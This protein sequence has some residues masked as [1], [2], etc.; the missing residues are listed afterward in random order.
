MTAAGVM[1]KACAETFARVALISSAACRAAT[2]GAQTVART[3]AFVVRLLLNMQSA[4]FDAMLR[5]AVAFREGSRQVVAEGGECAVVVSIAHQ[6]DETRQLIQEPKRSEAA[7]QSGMKMG[8]TILVQKSMVHACASLR[9]PSGRRMDYVRS[10]TVIVPAAEMYGKTIGFLAAGMRFGMLFPICAPDV[11]KRIGSQVAAVVLVLLGDAAS[12]NRKF[13]R[14]LVGMAEASG[15]PDNI[16]IDGGQ[17]CLIHQIQRLK[18]QLVDVHETVS[19]MYCLSRLARTGAILHLV[20]DH[21]AEMV[22]RRCKRIVG[23]PPAESQ[24]RSRRLLDILYKL[25][26][27]H[28]LLFTKT[29]VRKSRLVQDIETLL[30]VDNGGFSS[31]NAEIIHHCWNG[32]GPCCANAEESRQRMVTAYLNVFVTYGIPTASLSRWTHVQLVSSMLCCAFACRDVF[33]QAIWCLWRLGGHDC[34]NGRGSGG[35]SRPSTPLHF[36]FGGGG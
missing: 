18:C 35:Q 31:N 24:S 25:D 12:A 26:S 20:A 7:H 29:G 21:I 10:E 8:R 11:V 33:V 3:R 23:P 14:H 27:T 15:W 2:R 22:A 13:L 9:E 1:T 17:V 19:L 4:G 36:L 34:A 28:H 16:L 32:R 5:N 30:A 6:W